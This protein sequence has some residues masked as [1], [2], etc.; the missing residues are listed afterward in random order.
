[1]PLLLSFGFF[2]FSF[3]G[4][5]LAIWVMLMPSQG[6]RQGVVSKQ[7]EQ[8]EQMETGKCAGKRIEARPARQHPLVENKM[9]QEAYAAQR[10]L[11][12]LRLRIPSCMV[13]Y[14][15]N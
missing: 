11:S 10:E 13:Y 6:Q 8:E 4:P 2:G 3:L 7:D 9:I 5:V 12:D 15:Y 1:M 14:N